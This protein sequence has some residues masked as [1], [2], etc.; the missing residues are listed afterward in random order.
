MDITGI[1][2]VADFA[3]GIMDRFFPKQMSQE[4]KAKAQLDLETLIGERDQ[5]VAEAKASIIVAEMQQ[6]DKFTKRARP[7]VVYSG[8]VFI[9]LVHVAFPLIA[10]IVQIFCSVRG[11][12]NTLILPSLTL[13]TQFWW[14]WGSVVSVWELGRTWEKANGPG[15]KLVDLITG[16]K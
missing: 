1:G 2:S 7:M 8:L 11:I 15:N 4:E 9:G 6:G 10:S 5:K 14:A 3:K 12:T 13:P 16:G